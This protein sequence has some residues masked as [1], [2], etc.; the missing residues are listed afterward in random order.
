MACAVNGLLLKLGR[1]TQ[2][3]W[4]QAGPLQ[5]YDEMGPLKH[6]AGWFSSSF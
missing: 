3:P 2:Q 6:S 4:M 5:L 1:E